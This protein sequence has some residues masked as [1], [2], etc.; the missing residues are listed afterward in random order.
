K[1][2]TKSINWSKRRWPTTKS[3]AFLERRS[4]LIRGT[5]ELR[6]A[7]RDGGNRTETYPILDAKPS[8]KEMGP[9][10]LSAGTLKEPRLTRLTFDRL[11]GR[12][13]PVQ[14]ARPGPE[15]SRAPQPPRLPA[16]AKLPPA[17]QPRQ[18]EPV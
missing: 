9:F 2:F 6:R 17:G 14:P 10:Q 13:W 16:A 4:P 11:T 18:H 1:T 3:V 5:N 12:V 8:H 7:K 15:R